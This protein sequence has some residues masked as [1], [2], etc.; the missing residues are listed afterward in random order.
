MVRIAALMT[1]AVISAK[2]FYTSVCVVIGKQKSLIHD[3]GLRFGLF[4][5]GFEQ[6]AEFRTLL[7]GTVE[8]IQRIAA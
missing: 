2:R 1:P 4:F 8:F 5:G 6:G 3:F 7:A